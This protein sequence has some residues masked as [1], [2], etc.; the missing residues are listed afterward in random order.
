MSYSRKSV[1]QSEYGDQSEQGRKGYYRS[2]KDNPYLK[3]S[4]ILNIEGS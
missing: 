3:D 2:K 4:Q 1:D